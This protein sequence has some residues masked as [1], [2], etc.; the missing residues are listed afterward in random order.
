MGRGN[1]EEHE[2]G[3]ARMVGGLWDEIFVKAGCLAHR[4]EDRPGDSFED[5][6]REE[7][8]STSRLGRIRGDDLKQ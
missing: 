1:W 4:V 7:E 3:T 6:C 8:I 5:C 2:R